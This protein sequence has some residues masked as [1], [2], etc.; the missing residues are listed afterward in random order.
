MA[1]WTT[2]IRYCPK[3]ETGRAAALHIC[4][5]AALAAAG[6][7]AAAQADA[8]EAVIQSPLYAKAWATYAAEASLATTSKTQLPMAAPSGSV[9]D[10]WGEE[11][12]APEQSVLC[13]VAQR[14]GGSDIDSEGGCSA[15]EVVSQV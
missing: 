5:A 13:A 10:D 8:R 2:A 4:R 12:V 6:E 9:A 7:H 11:W 14:L 1:H 15:E 3:E